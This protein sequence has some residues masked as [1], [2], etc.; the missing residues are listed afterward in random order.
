MANP[1]R[2]EVALTVGDRT[3]TLVLDLNALCELEEELS[4]PDKV[5]TFGQVFL[6]AAN[7][8]GRACRAI[9]WASLRRHH[10]DMSMRDAADL[11]ERAGG[12]EEFF[13][14]V[15]KLRKTTE[16][17]GENRPR[18]ARQA[19]QKAGARTTSTPGESA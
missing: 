6:E 18:K 8:S 17:E 15:G 1:E 2:G 16:P 12:I 9:A 10:S 4:T 5:V 7:Y 14:T 11:I 19:K 13:S 3:Y